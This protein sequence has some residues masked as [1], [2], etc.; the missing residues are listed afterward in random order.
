MSFFTCQCSQF[1]THDTNILILIPSTYRYD[2][3]ISQDWEAG[4][5][6]H[7]SSLLVD[8]Y[9]TTDILQCGA[10]DLGELRASALSL[11][12]F[13]GNTDFCAQFWIQFTNFYI[14]LIAPAQYYESKHAAY[15]L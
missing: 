7:Q 2:K 14:V 1:F 8:G 4:D 5:R 11:R 10:W 15:G 13:A 12:P 3:D 6:C 9:T